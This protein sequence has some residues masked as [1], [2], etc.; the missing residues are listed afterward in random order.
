VDIGWMGPNLIIS[1]HVRVPLFD[2]EEWEKQKKG[3]IYIYVR[4]GG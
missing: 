3:K 1:F 2:K 4:R